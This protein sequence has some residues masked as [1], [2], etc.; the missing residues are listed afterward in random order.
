M[1]NNG[2]D[3]DDLTIYSNIQQCFLHTKIHWIYGPNFKG[4]AIK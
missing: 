4:L 2:G 1:I 3:G